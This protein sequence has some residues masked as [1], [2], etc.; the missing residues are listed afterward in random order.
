M[1]R[2][3]TTALHRNSN[4]SRGIRA[5][6]NADRAILLLP[7]RDFEDEPLMSA[8]VWRGG[9]DESE[10]LPRGYSRQV[11]RAHRSKYEPHVGAKQKAK[12]GLILVAR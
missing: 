7:P 6:I 12:A 1:A 10:E 9:S 2:K 4:R 5:Q 8:Q 3:Y 11:L